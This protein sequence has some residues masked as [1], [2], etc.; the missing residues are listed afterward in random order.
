[1]LMIPKKGYGHGPNNGSATNNGINVGNTNQFWMN[2]L[3]YNSWDIAGC[4]WWWRVGMDS[5]Q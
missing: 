2:T 3:H 5:L 1:M 4:L